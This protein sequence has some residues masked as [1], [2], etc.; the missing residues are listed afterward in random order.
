MNVFVNEFLRTA[1]LGAFML[2]TPGAEVVALLGDPWRATE[3]L[4]INIWQFGDLEFMI[5][6][7]MIGSIEL[8]LG[9]ISVALP[10]ELH[11]EDLREWTRRPMQNVEDWLTT[12][13]LAT[14]KRT[15]VGESARWTLTSGAALVFENGVAN[16]VS[17][18]DRRI[19][20]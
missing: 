20:G 8:M 6:D 3:E 10:P 9:D 4:S 2:G 1:K 18:L 14:K 15:T 19:G 16:S 11:V 17:V 12:V 7:G 13:G 5:Q